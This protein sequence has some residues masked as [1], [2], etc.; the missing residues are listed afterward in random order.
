MVVLITGFVSV[1]NAQEIANT[2]QDFY[3]TA[4]SGRYF[5]FQYTDL[6]EAKQYEVWIR[7]NLGAQPIT[8]ANNDQIVRCETSDGDILDLIVPATDRE[9]TL[10][11]VVIATKPRS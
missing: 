8:L 3:S 9:I 7:P 10:A 4:G 11:T 5:K 6:R 1:M 2:I